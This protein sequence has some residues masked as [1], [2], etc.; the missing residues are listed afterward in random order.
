M[1]SKNSNCVYQDCS[2]DCCDVYGYCPNFSSQ[3]YYYYHDSL[4]AGAIIGIVFAC[5]F[6]LCC[7]G[8]LGV[9]LCRKCRR[10]NEEDYPPPPPQPQVYNPNP[11]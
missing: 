2:L 3:C 10:R 5:L 9:I 7:T 1:G 8:I 4:S 6:I 11:P